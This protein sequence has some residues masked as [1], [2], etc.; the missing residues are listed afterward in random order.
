MLLGMRHL[1]YKGLAFEP[2]INQ[3]NGSVAFD[4]PGAVLEHKHVK[5]NASAQF[6]AVVDDGQL[7]AG[8]IVQRSG[9]DAGD[10]RVRCSRRHSRQCGREQQCSKYSHHASSSYW[11]LA[12]AVVP[13]IPPR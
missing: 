7:D 2:G 10:R 4:P 6:A 3:I 1:E 11:P 8:L 12:S 9:P 5:D 13:S